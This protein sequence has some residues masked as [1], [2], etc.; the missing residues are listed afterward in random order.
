MLVIF[1][2]RR[3]FLYTCARAHTHK[4]IDRIRIYR[5]QNIQNLK[6][7]RSICR[8]Q[9]VFIRLLFSLSRFFLFL[10]FLFLFFLLSVVSR[11]SS[12]TDYT[13]IKLYYKLNFV[14]FKK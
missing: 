8:A 10:F 4:H 12:Q 14:F 5:T 9:R 1:G 7:T 13:V 3:R 6:Y 2:D 11:L